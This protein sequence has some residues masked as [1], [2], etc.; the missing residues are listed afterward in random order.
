MKK[1]IHII[2]NINKNIFQKI[3]I[4]LKKELI[5]IYVKFFLK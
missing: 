3:I 1:F 2:L 4:L 5:I